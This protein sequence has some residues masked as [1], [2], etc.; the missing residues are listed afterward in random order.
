VRY[1]A[2]VSDAPDAP[3]AP[4]SSTAAIEPRIRARRLLVVV[5][6]M[7]LIGALDLLAGAQIEFGSVFTPGVSQF[8]DSTE[9]V[10]SVVFLVIAVVAVVAGLRYGEHAVLRVFVVF[11]VFAT[12]QVIVNIFSLVA[13]ST[14]RDDSYLWGV[15][16]V[17]AA[18]SMIVA[19]FTGWYW[20]ADH[21]IAAGAFEFP[22]T[23]GRPHRP[24]DII[25]YLF[26]AFNTNATFGPTTEAVVSR[27][28]K[29]LMMLQTVCSLLVLMVLVAR[30]VGLRN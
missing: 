18:Y 10:G 8:I 19:V 1:G 13:S 7:L 4:E 15:W 26:I 20:V 22:E 9:T 11:L 21:L 2:A 6:S 27:R 14:F 25:D 23:K 5:G 29:A 17:G 3:D 30:V 12:L 28:V 24:P 16:D